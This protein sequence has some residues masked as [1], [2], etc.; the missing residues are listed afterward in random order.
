MRGFINKTGVKLLN[1]S[2]GYH[3][4][5][6]MPVSCPICGETFYRA[7]SHVARVAVSTCSRACAAEASKVR[8]ITHCV[9]CQ[10]PME[11]T[12]TNAERITTCSK[13]CSTLRRTK[14]SKGTKPNALGVYIRAANRIVTKQEC[15]KCQTN[16]GPWAIRGLDAKLLPDGS[17]TLDESKAELWCR[18]CHLTEIAP[19]GPLARD[20]HKQGKRT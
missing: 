3:P 2:T 13:K 16:T 7:P 19:S 17:T 15:L 12:P 1:N 20:A 5:R 6:K 8:V 18:H 10:V 9:S 11:Q 4:N 14:G